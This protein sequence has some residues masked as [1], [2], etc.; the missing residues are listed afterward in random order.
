MINAEGVPQNNHVLNQVYANVLNKPILVPAGLPTS[1][2][3]GIFALLAAGAFPSIEDAQKTMCLPNKTYTPDPEAVGIYERLYPLFQS[4]YF[5]LGLPNAEAA[6]LG[7]VLPELRRIAARVLHT[8]NSA[9]ALDAIRSRS[10][11][12]KVVVE[13]IVFPG[14][15]SVVGNCG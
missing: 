10:S 13:C 5:A 15:N 3:S 11:K 4:L 1:L 2:G 7:D 8:P 12:V 6:R 9:D 14:F